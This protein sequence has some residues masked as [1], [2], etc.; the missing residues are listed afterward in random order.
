MARRHPGTQVLHRLRPA[1]PQDG[2][3]VGEAQG[4]QAA[5]RAGQRGPRLIFSPSIVGGMMRTCSV[6]LLLAS[7]HMAGAGRTSHVGGR[8]RVSLVSLMAR[9]AGLGVERSGLLNGTCATIGLPAASFPP[10]R[11]GTFPVH[12]NDVLFLLSFAT[13]LLSEIA[14]ARLVTDKTAGCAWT[15][16]CHPGY[17]CDHHVGVAC[18]ERAHA[19]A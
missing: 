12:A 18:G 3:G 17:L 11:R 4:R 10:L 16:F 2:I 5:V 9:G 7:R 15:T 13:V 6:D 14:S 1:D 19:S 8:H